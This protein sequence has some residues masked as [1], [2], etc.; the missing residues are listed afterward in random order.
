MAQR[1]RTKS[2]RRRPVSGASRGFPFLKM[3]P[4]RLRKSPHHIENQ[5]IP[6]FLPGGTGTLA[7]IFFIFIFL[8]F[9]PSPLRGRV[10]L[11]SPS[12]FGRGLG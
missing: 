5:T 1:K 10:L 3:N 4:E 6:L 11:I 2:A 7:G 9:T 12:P 8:F